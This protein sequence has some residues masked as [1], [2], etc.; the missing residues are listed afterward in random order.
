MRDGDRAKMMGLPSVGVG[1]QSCTC[2]V[3][4]ATVMA[5][6]T[7]E[8]DASFS[9]RRRPSTAVQTCS[10]KFSVLTPESELARARFTT[11]ASADPYSSQL[12]FES[13]SVSSNVIDVG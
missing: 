3:S 10:P 4:T 7:L 2:A 13:P 8:V 11:A 1:R 9:E 5:I 6:V 12:M